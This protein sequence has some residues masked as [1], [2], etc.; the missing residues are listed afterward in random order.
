MTGVQTCALP[1]YLN[2]IDGIILG[3]AQAVATLPGLS[4]AG[5]TMAMLSLR[6]FEKENML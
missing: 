2:T 3:L 6:G 4:R 5:T 1:I